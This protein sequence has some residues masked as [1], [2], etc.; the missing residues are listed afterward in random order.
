MYGVPHLLDDLGRLSPCA[1]RFLAAHAERVPFDSAD[2][3]GDE[4]LGAMLL[5]FGHSD[6]AALRRLR[7]AQERYAGLRYRSEA[8][9]FH[10][11]IE[12]GPWASWDVADGE[13]IAEF[14]DHSVAHPYAVWML[15]DGTI[16]YC[17]T[18]SGDAPIVRVFPHG[19]AMVESDAL[20]HR[21]ARWTRIDRGD[22]E[23]VNALESA[24]NASL[25]LIGEASG[26]TQRWWSGD[27]FYIHV[28][29]TEAAV[30][31]DRRHIR[32]AIWGEDEAGVSQARRFLA[33]AI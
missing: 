5:A 19:E 15:G 33:T 23:N 20:H 27:G 7:A 30:F 14:V 21:S 28:S 29:R 13:P 32:W 16:A 26:F 12:F 22:S 3:P 10:E 6:D 24:A 8:W 25:R 2:D 11:V 17:F 18:G 4:A 1:R 9:M 31:E